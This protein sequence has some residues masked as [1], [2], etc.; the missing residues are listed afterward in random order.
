VVKSKLGEFRTYE[1][2]DRLV[3]TGLIETTDWTA[4]PAG[5]EPAGDIGAKIQL[6]PALRIALLVVALAAV[7][8]GVR[9]TVAKFEASAAPSLSP[10]GQTD[11]VREEDVRLAIEVYK[12]AKGVY[13]DDLTQLVSEGLAREATPRKFIYTRTPE[14]FSLQRK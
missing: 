11:K 12:A 3:E 13:P 7:S 8:L 1:V 4:S 9:W 14:G 6:I 10:T 2:L 5:D